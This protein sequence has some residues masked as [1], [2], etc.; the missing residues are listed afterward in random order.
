MADAFFGNYEKKTEP[1]NTNVNIADLFK[2]QEY[3]ETLVKTREMVKPSE[4]IGIPIVI[5]DYKEDTMPDQYSKDKSE[6]PCFRMDFYFEDDESKENHFIRT[7]AKYLWD[8]LKTVDKVNPEL[9]R[10]GTVTAVILR[11]EKKTNGGF[12]TPFY[13]FEGTME[14]P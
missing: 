3:K 12:P 8:Y 14:K 2:K 7:E 6:K 5:K 13:Y 10:S 4:I 9:L 1:K 11:G